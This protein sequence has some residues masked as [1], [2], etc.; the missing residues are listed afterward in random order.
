[1][2]T[3]WFHREYIRFSGGHLKHSHYVG[4]VAAM[5]GF[6][7]K[8][9]F[10]GNPANQRL[11]EERRQLW[12]ESLVENLPYWQKCG[13]DILFV[14]GKD[15]R[16]V[17]KSA[18]DASHNPVIISYKAYATRTSI[19]NCMNFFRIG[20][21]VSVL[22]GRWPMRFGP[23]ARQTGR[24]LSFQTV[25]MLSRVPRRPCAVTT[26]RHLWW[27]LATKDRAWRNW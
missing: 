2:R 12:P 5:P 16:H 14:A 19:R 26:E 4:H 18:I 10:T 25:P 24:C 7:P 8:I 22:V 17:R 9:T 3:V 6:I 21:F 13:G 1:M 27:F 23:P 15:W 11:A 20:Q